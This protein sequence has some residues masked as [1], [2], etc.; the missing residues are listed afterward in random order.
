[1]S[2]N[3]TPEEIK[4]ASNHLRGA[5]AA[6]LTDA[7]NPFSGD[8]EIL[9]KFHGIYQQDNR[10]VLRERMQKNLPLEHICMVRAAVP[11]GVLTADQYLVMDRLPDEVADGTMRIT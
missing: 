1:M 6:E 9:L 8:S 11:G 2:A 3:A 5:I 10:D 7:E 4:A